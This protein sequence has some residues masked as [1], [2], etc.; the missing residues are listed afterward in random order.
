MYK[1]ALVSAEKGIQCIDQD[2]S[3]Q[4]Q[5]PRLRI[6]LLQLRA[7]LAWRLREMVSRKEWISYCT[8][9]KSNIDKV[10]R[11]IDCFQR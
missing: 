1:V 2:L 6:A 10:C 3:I 11:S 4:K 9:N 5:L 8:K 7:E